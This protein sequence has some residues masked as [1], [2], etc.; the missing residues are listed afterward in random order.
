V[1][2]KFDYGLSLLLVHFSTSVAKSFCVL[3]DAVSVA[4]PGL[5]LANFRT[6]RDYVET[7]RKEF[8][9]IKQETAEYYT[10]CYEQARFGNWKFK[11][12]EYGKFMQCVWEII[13]KIQ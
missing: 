10:K 4:R 2:S 13:E 8:P 12:D 7:L 5:R 1:L 11:E 6:I 3:E 9:G